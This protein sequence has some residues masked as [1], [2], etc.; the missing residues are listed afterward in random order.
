M[1]SGSAT[2]TGVSDDETLLV[3]AEIE[4]GGY[5]FTGQ[6]WQ[7]LFVKRAMSPSEVRALHATLTAGGAYCT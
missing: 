7:A 3:G 1:P 5:F 4:G 2:F 6:I